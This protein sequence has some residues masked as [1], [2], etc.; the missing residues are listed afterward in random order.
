MDDFRKAIRVAF[1]GLWS[2]VLDQS[3]FIATMQ[4]N[5]KFYLQRAWLEGANQCNVFEGELTFDEEQARNNFIQTQFA[6]IG[7]VSQA[8][9]DNS[10]AN[11]GKLRPLFER[12]ELW[13]TRYRQ[14][15]II[16]R[17]YA[18]A[19]QKEEWVLGLTEQHCPSCKG[20]AGRVYRNSTWRRY[21]AL[22]KSNDLFCSGYRCE[23]E[24]KPTDKPITPGPFPVR[25]L[26]P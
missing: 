26:S 20:F 5:I 15:V 18:C 22:P 8:I 9:V 7:D 24:L 3:D 2:G 17:T 19:D 25:L 21:N 1:R 16:A 23:C 13:V 12:A 4:F 14:L 11:G 10:K 6:Y